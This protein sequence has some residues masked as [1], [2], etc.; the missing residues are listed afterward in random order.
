MPPAASERF[1]CEF[2]EA[3]KRIEIVYW[4][5]EQGY[6]AGEAYF[7]GEDFG[8]P[9]VKGEFSNPYSGLQYKLHVPSK[10][11]KSTDA[12]LDVLRWANVGRTK[13]VSCTK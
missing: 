2:G 7:R 4:T 13:P 9:I 5:D 10:F 6:T 12:I 3:D 8:A 1:A 11:G